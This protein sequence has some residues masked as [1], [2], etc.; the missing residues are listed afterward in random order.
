M[1]YPWKENTESVPLLSGFNEV[2]FQNQTI[3]VTRLCHYTHNDEAEGID[4]GDYFLFKPKPIHGKDHINTSRRTA[5]ICDPTNQPPTHLT[6]YRKVGPEEELFPGSYVWWFIDS[7]CLPTVT[8][9]DPSIY[10]SPFN[11]YTLSDPFIT[12]YQ[13]RYGNKKIS[14]DLQQLCNS[15]SQRFSGWVQFRCGGT[16]RYNKQILKVVI[17]CTSTY[18]RELMNYPLMPLLSPHSVRVDIHNGVV[19]TTSSSLSY[20]CDTYAFIF[21]FPNESYELKCYKPR[22]MIYRSRPAQPIVQS[23]YFDIQDVKHNISSSTVPCCRKVKN[24]HQ[25]FVCPNELPPEEKERKRRAYFEDQTDTKK[26][27]MSYFIT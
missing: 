9:E 24:Q 8:E 27:S 6:Q 7:T 10:Q 11:R 5:V 18:H 17:V 14:A 21:Y 15:Y 3:T 16:L 22:P 1:H 26:R 13:S 23:P 19:R 12:P 2:P 25:I 20:S 4:R